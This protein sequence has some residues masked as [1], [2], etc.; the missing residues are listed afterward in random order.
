MNKICAL[1]LAATAAIAAIATTGCTGDNG[2]QRRAVLVRSPLGSTTDRS[3]HPA[4]EGLRVELEDP[5]ISCRRP[6]AACGPDELNLQTSIKNVSAGV[7]CANECPACERDGGI[8]I[9]LGP[10]RCICA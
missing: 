6:A 7:P 2:N 8:C 4:D 1:I 3:C 9:H 5:A 10:N